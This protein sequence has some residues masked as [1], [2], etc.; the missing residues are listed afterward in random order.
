MS[1]IS[2]DNIILGDVT[3]CVLTNRLLSQEIT[4]L[5]DQVDAE[6]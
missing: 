5:F 2:D 3:Q 1:V 4:S 6:E